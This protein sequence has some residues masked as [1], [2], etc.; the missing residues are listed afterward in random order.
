MH[1]HVLK[2]EEE[3][4]ARR[5]K[6]MKL[7]RNEKKMEGFQFVGIPLAHASNRRL[8]LAKA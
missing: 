5:R 3:E 1:R 7:T 6:W 4:G 2:E 8:R